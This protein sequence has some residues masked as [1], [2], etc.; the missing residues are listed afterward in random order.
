VCAIG[1]SGVQ[2]LYDPFRVAKPLKRVGPRG[3]GKWKAIPW[4][5]AVAEIV[6]G[7][8][9]FGEGEVKGLK[10]VKQSGDAL[11]FLAGR[12]DWGSQLFVKRFLSE[13][14][15]SRLL[16]DEE[17]VWEQ[18][19]AAAA[20]SVFGPGTGPVDA[21]Y[22]RVRFL[23]SFGDAPLD[24]G[25]PLVSLAR[26]IADARVKGP[27]LSWAVVDPRL[28]TSASK[29]DLWVPAIPG[30]DH[31][32]ALAIM[33]SLADQ[34]ADALRAPR[35]IVDKFVAGRSMEDMAAKCGISPEIPVKLA[36]LLAREGGRSAVIPGR[37]IFAQLEGAKVAEAILTL[38][39]LVGSKPGTGGIVSRSNQF[40]KKAEKKLLG[41]AAERSWPA[42]GPA[43]S[44]K[45]MVMWQADPVYGRPG[46][47]DDL[48]RNREKVGLLVAIDSQVTETSGLADYI[49]PDTTYLERWDVCAT[50][51]SVTAPG[52]GVRVPVVGGFG[53]KTGTYLAILP[54]A[55]IM[56]DT[57][58]LM[59]VA[60]GFAGYG[61]DAPGGVR[62]AWDYYRQAVPTA[63]EALKDSGVKGLPP[64]ADAEPIFERG[65]VFGAAKSGSSVK[66]TVTGI[67]NLKVSMP[68]PSAPAAGTGDESFLLITYSL[69]FHRSVRSGVN[70]WLLEILPENRL[71]VNASDAR[72]LKIG[73]G[74]KV[75]VEALEQ[76]TRVE[77]RAQVIPGIRPGVVA[78]ARGF[79]SR[80]L[81]AAPYTID[82]VTSVADKTRAA[83]V[84]V[85]SL[86]SQAGSV[87]VSIRRA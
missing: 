28:S 63:F 24:S 7:G 68:R 47:A 38:N 25:V 3:S 29:S 20:D 70:S 82:G 35:E 54:E 17:A 85:S 12:W 52:F 2:S 74:D 10:A 76:K 46:L 53:V 45:A 22:S 5:Q 69:P 61:P 57:L 30:T 67:E 18:T 65:G 78:L 60:L 83:G 77:C 37:G 9:L 49:L 86:T 13:F 72:M 1:G 36:A 4:E 21:D 56:E 62:N 50:P 26:Q 48:F 31:E 34:H 71:L 87:K 33:K 39:L 42:E 15:G 59:G 44:A 40:L 66:E 58:I 41:K 64:L 43:T 73:Q 23:L 27:C 81:G 80:G 55:R 16:S 19:A 8:N 75:V 79:G 14:P 84:N 32:L 6:G 51:P 11:G